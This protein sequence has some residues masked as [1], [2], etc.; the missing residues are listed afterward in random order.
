MSPAFAASCPQFHR[1]PFSITNIIRR[2]RHVGHY[3]NNK[4]TIETTES[5][6]ASKPPSIRLLVAELLGFVGL[7]VGPAGPV[8]E[9][10]PPPPPPPPPEPVPLPARTQATLPLA[11]CRWPSEPSWAQVRTTAHMFSSA[12]A[13]AELLPGSAGAVP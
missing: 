8:P 10:P 9:P 13:T 12:R 3:T 4:E 6:K 1:L 5:T 2:E 11:E 7:G